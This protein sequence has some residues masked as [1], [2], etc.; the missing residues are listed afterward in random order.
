MKHLHC[1]ITILLLWCTN[2][3]NF[4]RD[5]RN[6]SS[7]SSSDSVC[8][9]ATSGVSGSE[10]SD[11]EGCSSESESGSYTSSDGSSSTKSSC[12]SSPSSS[13]MSVSSSADAG[14]GV[15]DKKGQ[16]QIWEICCDRR[17]TLTEVCL[18]AGLDARRITLS[19]GYD[20]ATEKSRRKAARLA[21]TA[22][23]RCYWISTPCTAYSPFQNLRK[24]KNKKQS[25]R[26]LRAKKTFR[27]DRSQL[28][29]CN[30]T[31]PLETRM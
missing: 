9:E 3:H 6:M 22:R 20:L 23:P 5:Q 21:E 18:A 13:S 28:L 4:T 25:Q 11:N 10:E 29:G 7:T 30:Q 16:Q 17:S 26:R 27:P 15:V 8:E 12:R 2:Q 24:N 14:H 1:N 31:I 19:T